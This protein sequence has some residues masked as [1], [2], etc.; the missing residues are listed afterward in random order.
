MVDNGGIRGVIPV[1]N[2]PFHDNDEIDFSTL[3]NAVRW[4]ISHGVDGLATG[5]VSEFLKLSPTERVALGQAICEAAQ[6]TEVAI[7]LS[8]GAESTYETAK[9]AYECEKTGASAVM[10]NPPISM[11]LPDD[12][13][14]GY[15]TQVFRATSIPVIVQ[16]ASGYVGQPISTSVLIDLF[17]QYPDRIYFKPEATP[18]GQRVSALRDATQGLG[19]IFEGT[20]GAHLVDTFQRGVIGTMPGADLPWLFTSLWNALSD[21]NW[22]RVN[23]INGAAAN[24][25]ILMSSLDSYVTIEKY[26]LVKQNVYPNMNVRGPIAF[27]LDDEAKSE[28]DRLFE[29]CLEVVKL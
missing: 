24:L 4:A 19:R 23:A 25:L 27:E 13:L 8:C 21:G 28:L 29:A 11:R 6:G 20:G 17:N 7:V 3:Q 10:V 12:Q 22:K 14:L 18:I 9:L 5:M 15:Y 1:L 2:T 16:D 26:F